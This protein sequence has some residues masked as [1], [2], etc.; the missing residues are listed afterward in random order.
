MVSMLTESDRAP[1]RSGSLLAK[2]AMGLFA[3]ALV[4][5]C[6]EWVLPH[7][8]GFGNDHD[9]TL[10]LVITTPGDAVQVPFDGVAVSRD[11]P[12]ERPAISDL[13][14]PEGPALFALRPRAPPLA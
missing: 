9:C 3:L 14:V 13:T 4:L 12:R 6:L 7:H 1:S 11:L 10:C 2:S 5:L 8:H